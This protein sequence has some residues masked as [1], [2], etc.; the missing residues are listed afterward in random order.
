MD[1]TNK[2]IFLYKKKEDFKAATEEY[3]ESN[4]FSLNVDDNMNYTNCLVINENDAQKLI[5]SGKN[6]SI[7]YIK[8]STD[9][10]I[11]NKFTIIEK[12]YYRGLVN[13]DDNLHAL[14]SNEVLL[15]GEDKLVI[16]NLKKNS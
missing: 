12:R 9:N 13:I 16:F 2:E 7:C 10:A 5:F 14:T 4:P 3:F 8:S 6:G 11:I 15:N 1:C